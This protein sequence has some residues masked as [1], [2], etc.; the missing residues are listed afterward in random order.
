[1]HQSLAQVHFHL[2]F[3]TRP[4]KVLLHEEYPLIS[5][6]TS[7]AR[8]RFPKMR[9]AKCIRQTV[10]EIEAF[11]RPFRLPMFGVSLFQS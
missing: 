5:S 1:M 3:S 4:G 11:P 2:N 10:G 7:P 9:G 8:P 6:L